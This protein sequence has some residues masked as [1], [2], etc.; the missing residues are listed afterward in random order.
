[1]PRIGTKVQESG[2]SVEEGVEYTISRVNWLPKS[3][4]GFDNYRVMCV[5][6]DSDE[7]HMINLWD[8]EV[9]TPRSKLGSF[10]ITFGN[11]T[12]DWVGRR[13]RL[14]R[15]RDRERVIEPLP[16]KEAPKAKTKAGK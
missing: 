10:L 3:S 2:D 15:W 9:A 8:R 5:P 11:N 14:I 1:M 7:E 16:T 4:A 12:D 13:F 6:D